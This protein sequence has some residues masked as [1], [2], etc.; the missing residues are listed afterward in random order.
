MFRALFIILLLA[1]LLTWG[2]LR[3]ATGM[4]HLLLVIALVA[5]VLHFIR[6]R[7]ARV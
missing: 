7:R 5:L 2:F 1:W 3:I 6:G 4:V